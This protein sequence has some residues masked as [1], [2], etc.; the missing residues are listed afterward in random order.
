MATDDRSGNWEGILVEPRYRPPAVMTVPLIVE[1]IGTEVVVSSPPGPSLT[2]EAA[3][4]TARRLIAAAEI[5]EGN[6]FEPKG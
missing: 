6:R 2:P 4:E 5:A 3:R 1:A